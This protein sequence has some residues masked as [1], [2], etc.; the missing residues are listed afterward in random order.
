VTMELLTS[1]NVTSS[2]DEVDVTAPNVVPSSSPVNLDSSASPTVHS[3][4]RL[5]DRRWSA[6]DD[7]SVVSDS[8]DVSQ[9]YC[10]S[11]DVVPPSK[12]ISD[13]QTLESDV[14]SVQPATRLIYTGLS[15]RASPQHRILP[16]RWLHDLVCS[17][18]V[19]ALHRARLVLGWV[20]VCRQVNYLIV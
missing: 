14:V 9:Q 19:L 11:A 2:S 12:R 6:P 7:C 4:S 15:S 1:A 16:V 10:H 17:F 20:T 5:S 3:S 13:W 8:V 18:Y